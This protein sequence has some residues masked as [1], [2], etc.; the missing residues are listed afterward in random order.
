MIIIMFPRIIPATLHQHPYIL[1][2]DIP[3]SLSSVITGYLC[4]FLKVKSN[5]RLEHTNWPCSIA[6]PLMK[7]EMKEEKHQGHESIMG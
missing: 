5:S 4:L 3:L 1:H 7:R 2:V 6:W